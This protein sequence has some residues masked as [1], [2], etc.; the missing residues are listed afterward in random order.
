M[1][2]IICYRSVSLCIS[3]RLCDS[4]ITVFYTNDIISEL[5]GHHSVLDCVTQSDFGYIYAQRDI[6]TRQGSNERI[7]IDDTF[8]CNEVILVSVPAPFLNDNAYFLLF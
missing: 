7:T 2:L 5:N 6:F 1:N 8:F 3:W 4:C